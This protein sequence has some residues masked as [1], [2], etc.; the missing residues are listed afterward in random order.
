MITV[1]MRQIYWLDTKRW[2]KNIIKLQKMAPALKLNDELY[3]LV[4]SWSQRRRSCG[5]QLRLSGC[6][7]NTT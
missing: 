3:D 4:G 6:D 7:H 5:V 2:N 1:N